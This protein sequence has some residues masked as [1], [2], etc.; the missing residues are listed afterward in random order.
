M[1][2]CIKG[3]FV[4]RAS[5]S[6]QNPRVSI[7]S[8]KPCQPLRDDDAVPEARS[9]A[10]DPSDV[11]GMNVFVLHDRW[12]RCRL[13]PGGLK[14]TACTTAVRYHLLSQS[15]SHC[16]NHGGASVVLPLRGCQCKPLLQLGNTPHQ[17]P[18]LHGVFLSRVC[19]LGLSLGV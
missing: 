7:K 11:T 8:Q 14:C 1:R 19:Q 10:F 18:N 9:L 13:C 5:Q 17:T 16:S 2:S 12:Q 15:C 6:A 4:V 3:G